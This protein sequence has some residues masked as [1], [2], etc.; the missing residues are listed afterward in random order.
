MSCNYYL[1]KTLLGILVC[2]CL[3]LGMSPLLYAYNNCYVIINSWLSI[4][5]IYNLFHLKSVIFSKAYYYKLLTKKLKYK[6]ERMMV[7]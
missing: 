6:P 4:W 2:V 5:K 7:S 3:W 1:F